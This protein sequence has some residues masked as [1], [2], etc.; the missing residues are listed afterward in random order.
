MFRFTHEP[1]S[2]SR[3]QR[4]AKITGMVPAYLL[5]C[6]VASAMPAYSKLYTVCVDPYAG[7]YLAAQRATHTHNRLEYAAIALATKHINGHPRTHTGNFR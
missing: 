6:F 1:S 4:L 5:I 7:R 2:G 3:S